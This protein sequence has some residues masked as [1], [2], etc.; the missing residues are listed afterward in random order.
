[1]ESLF[2]PCESH[3]IL[4]HFPDDNNLRWDIV[5]DDI[6]IAISNVVI[7]P[8]DDYQTVV[9]IRT[10]SD[11]IIVPEDVNLRCCCLLIYKATRKPH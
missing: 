7:F 6:Q 3:I 8:D 5:P 4:H 1:M 10:I 11:G 9:Q 2:Q